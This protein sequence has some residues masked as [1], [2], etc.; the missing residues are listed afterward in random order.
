MQPSHCH[1]I[2]YCIF[3][4][5]HLSA[6]CAT[7]RTKSHMTPNPVI[8]RNYE[9]I[10][11]KSSLQVAVSSLKR[12][13]CETNDDLCGDQV[14]ILDANGLPLCGFSLLVIYTADESP[15]WQMV[16]TNQSECTVATPSVSHDA[17][18]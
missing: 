15:I 13:S 14:E 18:T 9:G 4:I 2:I 11:R 8:R 3:F 12:S 7:D 5:P 6:S 1:L 10:V 17:K 16:Y